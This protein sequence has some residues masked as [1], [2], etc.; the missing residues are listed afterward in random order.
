MFFFGW[1]PAFA[2]TSPDRDRRKKSM[3]LVIGVPRFGSEKFPGILGSWFVDLLICQD[4][5][6]EGTEGRE[7]G[8]KSK[9]PNSTKEFNNNCCCLLC[10]EESFSFR[11]VKSQT[12]RRTVVGRARGFSLC[13]FQT[14]GF[15]LVTFGSLY[16]ARRKARLQEKVPPC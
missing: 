6:E 15:G 11:Q 2:A 13:T 8:S 10:G 5:W 4:Y 14:P 9:R 7:S 12:E 1:G 3:V 16:E